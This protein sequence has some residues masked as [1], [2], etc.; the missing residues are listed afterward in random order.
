MEHQPE[1]PGPPQQRTAP[2]VIRQKRNRPLERREGE[3]GAPRRYGIGTIMIVTAAAAMLLGVFNV[4]GVPP[5]VVI[6]VL[7]FLVLIGL[8]QIILY[9]G[10]RPRAASVVTGAIIYPVGFIL[11]SLG[12]QTLSGHVSLQKVILSVGI[13]IP[14]GVIMGAGAG[15]LAGGLVGGIFLVM[16]SVER[17]L[18]KPLQAELVVEILSEKD[19]EENA[20]QHSTTDAK[21][22][23]DTGD[24]SSDSANIHPLD[25]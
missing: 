2:R 6:P 4:I 20:L 7:V 17:A 9:Q 13:A 14:I 21:D 12:I 3:F 19:L 25:R 11:I 1:Y 15:Y 24:G 18:E 22:S 10:V 23:S 16:D 5:V 8:G